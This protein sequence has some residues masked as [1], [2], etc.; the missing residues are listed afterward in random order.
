MASE[1]KAPARWRHVVHEVIFEAD[2]FGGKL[3]DVA[4]LIAILLSIAAVMLESVEK[5]GSEYGTA[6]RIVEWGLTGAFT[7]EY[8]LRLISVDRPWRYAF[9]FFGIVDLLAILPTYLSVLVPGAQSLA[10][11]R[12]LRL[13][14]V[15]RVLNLGYFVKEASELGTALR[16]SARKILIFLGTVLTIV[17]IM[18]SL[19]YV[20]EGPETGFTSVPRGVYW[21]VVTMT[22]VGYGDI[23]PAT[24]V[25]QSVAAVLMICGY[26][27]I[28][29]PTGIVSV[30]LSRSR[31]P[32][33]V[34]TRACM[35]CSLE[36]HDAD[37]GHCKFCGEK[38]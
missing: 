37:A 30:D 21:A 20:L 1:R 6:L 10:V 22:T 23:A 7:V 36:G 13:L 16:R 34:S 4:L 38:L 32:K 11:I 2:T 12:A 25:G 24:V 18:G 29:V 17:V 5:I 31:E 9:S 35:S 33:P 19:M 8:V 28:A 26:A 3:F 27:I 14:R 15:F